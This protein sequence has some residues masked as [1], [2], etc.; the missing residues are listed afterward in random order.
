MKKALKWTGV[1]LA[2]LV[3]LIIILS[4]LFYFPPFQNWAVRQAARVASEKTGMTVTVDNVRLAFPLDLSL[5]GVKMMEPNDSIKGKTDTVADVRSL[6]VSVEF[7][8]LLKKQVMVD[9][10]SLLQAKVNTTPFISNVRISGKVGRLKVRAH[11]IDL[12][13]EHVRVNSAILADADI[14]VALADTAKRD[15]TPSQNFW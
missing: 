14:N 12:S 1:G 10:L 15:T 9:D 4:L 6:V 13:R 11:G 5:N 8:P 3:A 7:M 2:S